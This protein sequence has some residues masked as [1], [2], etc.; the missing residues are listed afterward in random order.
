[1]A[2][3]SIQCPGYFE[4]GMNQ[5]VTRRHRAI[6]DPRQ[7]EPATITE[8]AGQIRVRCGSCIDGIC[9]ASIGKVK[10]DIY[11]EKHLDKAR[12]IKCVHQEA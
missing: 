6:D 3:T 11:E 5:E 10:P 8:V 7:W 12:Q 9:T 4:A 2:I 1:M